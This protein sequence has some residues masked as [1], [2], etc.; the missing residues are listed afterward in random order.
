MA[1]ILS[2]D[3]GAK[4]T[5]IAVTDPLQIIAS[6][7]TTVQTP[8]IWKFLAEYFA[9]EEVE[10][11][12]VGYPVKMNNE[13]SEA[14]QF[15]KPFIEK[16]QKKYPHIP[17]ELVDERFSSKMAMQSMIQGGVKKKKRRDKSLVDMVSAAIILQTFLEEQTA[18]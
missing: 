6:G 8:Q 11:I 5:G 10:T 14:M 1:R 3:Y 7:L 16:L 13:P 12:V 17:V 15:V 18:K 9:K 2:I 4:R